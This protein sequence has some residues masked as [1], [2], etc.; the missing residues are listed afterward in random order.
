M[1]TLS[2][3]SRH[4]SVLLKACFGSIAD[5]EKRI[6]HIGEGMK[7]DYSQLS[8]RLFLGSGLSVIGAAAA[9]AAAP[10]PR[11]ASGP[12][13][14]DELPLDADNDLLQ[15][16]GRSKRAAGDVL[17]LF[18]RVIRANGTPVSGAEVEI[19]QCDSEGRYHHPRDPRGGSQADQDFQG[20]GRTVSSGEGGYRFRTIVPAPYPGRTPHVH[21]LVRQGRRDFVTQMYL[22]GHSGNERDTLYRRLSTAEQERLSVVLERAEGVEPGARRCYFEIVLA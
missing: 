6:D 18:G 21:V 17:H 12:Y 3:E 20:F 7:Q 9:R 4:Y 10:T 11:Q 16:A 13:Y 22:A 2:R 15:I 8:R 5:G 1:L 14:P 19:W